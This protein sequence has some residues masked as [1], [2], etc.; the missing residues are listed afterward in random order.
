L[1]VPVKILE[2]HKK[3]VEYMITTKREGFDRFY[4][5]DLKKLIRK[6]DCVM[7]TL[8]TYLCDFTA[9]IFRQFL[10]CRFIW[11]SFVKIIA[12]IDCLIALH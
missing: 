1:E 4:T 10:D 2:I 5:N 11:D 6:R 8:R 3:P 12:E 7:E 9:E